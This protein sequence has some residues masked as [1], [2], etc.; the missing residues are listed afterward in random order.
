MTLNELHDI[1]FDM[2]TGC[3]KTLEQAGVDNIPAERWEE[4]QF[5]L[6]KAQAFLQE[7]FQTTDDTRTQIELN[8]EGNNNE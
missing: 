7:A 4:I 8:Q 1:T 6:R 2:W 3:G 5:Y